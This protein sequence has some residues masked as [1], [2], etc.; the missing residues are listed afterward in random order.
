MSRIWSP[1]QQ[2]IFS[3]IED[4][5]A[6]NAIVKAVAGS[7]KSTTLVEGVNRVKGSH[8]F[9]A[10]NKSI[11]DELKDRGVNA[12]TFHSLTFSP[13]LSF[14]G[15]RNVETNKLRTLCKE[16]MGRDEFIYGAF[17]CRLVGLARNAGVGALVPDSEGA[18]WELAERHDLQP[19]SERADFK[20]GLQ[21]ASQLLQMSNLSKMVDFDDLLYRAVLDDIALPKFDFVFVDEAQDTNAIQR[22]LLKKIMKPNSRLV[23]VGDPAQ[24]IYG[25]RGADSESMQ[26]IADEFQCK[27]LPLTISYRCPTSVVKYAQQWVKHIEAAPNA[28]EGEVMH[29]GQEWSPTTFRP[30]ELVVCRT[31]KP[32]I[33]LAFKLVKARVPVTV[34]GREIGQGLVTLIKK[35]GAVDIDGLE[36]KLDA[37]L[38]RE[39]NKAMVKEEEEKV[40]ALGDKHATIMTLISGLVETNR[41]IPDLI[42]CIE[43]LFT[44]KA[45]AV[46]LATIHKA[47]G[48][49][50]KVVYWLN[51]SQC[52]SKWARQAWQ[53]EQE[54]NLCYVATTRA[55][56][57]LVLIEAPK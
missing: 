53:V 34:V 48:L 50:A 31:T 43:Y 2:A 1:Y 54:Y 22:A 19:D 32:L 37:W 24:A 16:F 26:M 38:E 40:A 7:G 33:A 42:E 8:I 11:A 17:A 49:E 57:S 52:P 21:Y 36:L 23:A 18:M 56:E 27:E 44:D 45:E 14:L 35:M 13:V 3:H 5:T 39:T 9:L 29:L 55:M 4:P 25:F 41:T 20:R 47:K 15:Q 10:F 28:P 6:G 46:K 30:G 12:R 51:S